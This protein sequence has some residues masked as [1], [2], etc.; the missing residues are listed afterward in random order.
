[1]LHDSIAGDFHNKATI[2]ASALLCVYMYNDKTWMETVLTCF[3]KIIAEQPSLTQYERS[4]YHM[5]EKLICYHV[6]KSVIIYFQF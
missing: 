4:M 2:G 1:M 3:T 6:L 5:K